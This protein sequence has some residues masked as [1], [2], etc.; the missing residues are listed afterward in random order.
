MEPRAG[1]AGSLRVL[2]VRLPETEV[3]GSGLS[4]MGSSL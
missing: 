4:G 2:W 1:E 3:Q